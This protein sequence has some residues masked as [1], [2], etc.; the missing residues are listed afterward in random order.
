MTGAVGLITAVVP[1]P[2]LGPGPGTYEPGWLMQVM[3]FL[4]MG[5]VLYF[6]AVVFTR[7]QRVARG[8][9]LWGPFIVAVLAMVVPLGV[10]YV[11]DSIERARSTDAIS[12]YADRESQLVDEVK[13]QLEEAFGISYVDDYP[14]VPLDDGDYSREMLVLPDGSTAECFTVAEDDGYYRIRCG[15]DQPED[16]VELEPVAP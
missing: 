7:E 14:Y 3:L 8:G 1:V 6:V 16:G 11:I 4:A 10:A 15:G 13:A 5:G 2:N 9:S 12:E